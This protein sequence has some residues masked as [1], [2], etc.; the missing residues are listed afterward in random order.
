MINKLIQTIQNRS[1]IRFVIVGCINTLNYYILYVL[2]MS[3]GGL[4]I[5][6]HSAAFIISMVGSFYLNCYFTYRTKPTFAKFFQFPLT[7]VVNYSVSTFSLFLL[8][9]LLHFNEFLAPLIAAII[10]IPFTY[11]I[12]KIILEKE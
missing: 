9:D 1:F 6:S 8:V 3:L 2:F 10:P 5:I 12:S 7:Y 4:Y 11:I